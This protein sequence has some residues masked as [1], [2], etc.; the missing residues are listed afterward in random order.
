[1]TKQILANIH[2]QIYFNSTW[3]T[4]THIYIYIYI[5]VCMIH[6]VGRFNS[7]AIKHQH[8]DEELQYL[9]NSTQP[10]GFVIENHSS[11]PFPS[12]P[13]ISDGCTSRRGCTEQCRDQLTVFYVTSSFG[14]GI[15][16]SSTWVPSVTLSLAT[17]KAM[18]TWKRHRMNSL[19]VLPAF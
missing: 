12:G 16:S 6:I 7:N 5:Y 2:V 14:Q 15:V 11:L 8:V 17:Q 9:Y 18:T 1:M 13:D 19:S 4:H 10:N 3:H